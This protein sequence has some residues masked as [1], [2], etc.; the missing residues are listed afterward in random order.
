VTCFPLL[1]AAVAGLF[2][3]VDEHSSVISYARNKKASTGEA[4]SAI[5][6]FFSLRTSPDIQVLK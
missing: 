5:F 1:P 6:R 4:L 3:Y 2:F